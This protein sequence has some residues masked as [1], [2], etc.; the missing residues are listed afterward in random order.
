MIPFD[1]PNSEIHP[2]E[3]EIL[4]KSIPIKHAFN[5]IIEN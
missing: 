4:S 2:E 3:L 5:D 1:I